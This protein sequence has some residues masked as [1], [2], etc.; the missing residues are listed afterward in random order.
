MRRT[1]RAILPALLV[2]LLAPLAQAS[3]HGQSAPSCP[4]TLKAD[5]HGDGSVT[6]DWAPVAGATSYR[7]HRAEGDGPFQADHAR[8][9][10][11][12]TSYR[13]AATAPGVTYRYVVTSGDHAAQ[14]AGAGGAASCPG[15]TVKPLP[16]VPG[17]VTAMAITCFA[18][19]AYAVVAGTRRA[20][21]S[22]R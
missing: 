7:I 8:V 4:A 16:Y 9:A 21:V 6:L 22:R 1:A 19:L 17:L 18:L 14:D 12:A 10:A 15:V 11:P 3:S 2:L 5:A 20:P 13:D